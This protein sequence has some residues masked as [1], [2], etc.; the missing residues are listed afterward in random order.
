MN[1]SAGATMQIGESSHPRD[2]RFKINFIVIQHSIK[3][4]KQNKISSMASKEI[5]KVSET[6]NKPIR[7]RHTDHIYHNSK[8]KEVFRG[9]LKEFP[10][11]A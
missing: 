8:I 2:S 9:F 1:V 3:D 7:V 11:V 5:S 6:I 10:E 4:A